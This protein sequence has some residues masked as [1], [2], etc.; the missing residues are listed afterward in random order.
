MRPGPWNCLTCPADGRTTGSRACYTG[1]SLCAFP[2][3]YSC[4]QVEF[5]AKHPFYNNRVLSVLGRFQAR[6]CSQS[7][8]WCQHHCHLPFPCSTFQRKPIFH[9]QFPSL[10]LQ[11]VAEPRK[12]AQR[13]RC[14]QG[15]RSMASAFGK[16]GYTP[17]LWDSGCCSK[18]PKEPHSEGASVGNTKR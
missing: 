8:W 14:M 4:E 16:R 12:A 10:P 18:V 15:H 5:P 9:T 1:F 7:Q 2:F 13:P 17:S 6:T 3:L 11:P